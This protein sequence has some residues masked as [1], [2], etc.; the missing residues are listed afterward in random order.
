[1][2]SNRDGQRPEARPQLP[3]RRRDGLDETGRLRGGQPGVGRCRGACAVGV[4]LGSQQGGHHARRHQRRHEQVGG[5]P[6][7]P[8]RQEQ[9][10]GAGGEAAHAPA[11][12]R[13]GRHQRLPPRGRHG[14]APAVDHHVLRRP[15]EAECHGEHDRP[16]QPVGRI[17]ERDTRQRQH[18][19]E[20]RGD[21]PAAPAP[22]QAAEPRRVVAVEER[23]PDELELVGQRHLAQQAQRRDPHARLRQPG[24]LR[25]VDQ[26]ERDTRA[27]AQ[28]EHRREPAVGEWIVRQRDRPRAPPRHG[29]VHAVAPF[30]VRLQAW[31]PPC[32]QC[33]AAP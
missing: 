18:H 32:G 8:V 25:D 21:D 27:E 19:R 29:T 3:D 13:P 4:R 26:Q 9:R 5:P 17:A 28:D 20:L 14:D 15:G 33:G 7:D 24:R 30:R 10:A 11:D 2:T 31:P 6:A 23:R 16:G 22:Q 1:M 12:L